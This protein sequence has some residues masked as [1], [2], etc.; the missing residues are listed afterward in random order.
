MDLD[1]DVRNKIIQT[2][3]DS[4]KCKVIYLTIVGS[5]I[6]GL[7][8][9][10][11]S[12]YDIHCILI[13]P[14]YRE[15]LNRK[16][17]AHKT[18]IIIKEIEYDIMSYYYFDYFHAQFAKPTLN[19]FDDLL[20]YSNPFVK[21][22]N[23]FDI[24]II[25]DI[26]IREYTIPIN[27]LYSCYGI[28]KDILKRELTHKKV[29]ALLRSCFI[30]INYL[31]EKNINCF[32]YRFA[33]AFEQFKNNMKYELIDI[34]ESYEDY[35]NSLNMKLNNRGKELADP[36]IKD[37][38][39]Q[40]VNYCESK[41]RLF[42]EEKVD[43]QTNSLREIECFNKLNSC[44]EDFVLDLNNITNKEQQLIFTVKHKHVYKERLC[45][46]L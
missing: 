38:L 8:S 39:N 1:E 5:Y 15:F 25:K 45:S 42:K 11:N 27:A 24:S 9:T 46:I 34:S 28:A 10:N 23:N 12:D 22:A 26:L 4:T 40:L 30:I 21:Q 13:Y 31:Q 33:D 2:V 3:E 20:G 32:V 43:G 17:T 35:T 19:T 7:H 41:I 44:V 16:H 18:N 36:T 29:L 37:S 6:Q 14:R